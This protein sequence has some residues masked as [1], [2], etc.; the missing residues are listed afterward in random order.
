MIINILV[1]DSLYH[2]GIRVPKIDFKMISVTI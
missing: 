1:L 2:N